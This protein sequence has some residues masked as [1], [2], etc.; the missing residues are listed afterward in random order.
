MRLAGGAIALVIMLFPAAL[1]AQPP[2]GNEQPPVGNEAVKMQ[3]GSLSIYPSLAIR[4]IGVDENVFNESVDPKSDFTIT[5]SPRA[6]ISFQPGRLKLTLSET[7]D[8][9]YFQTFGSEGGVNQSVTARADVDLGVIQPYAT[10]GGAN[11]KDRYNHEVDARARHRDRT[12]SAGVGL[13]LFT[14]TTATAGVRRIRY[15]FDE[16]A[17]FRGENLADAFNSTIDIVEGGV[18]I[19]VTPLTKFAVNVSQEDQEFDNTVDRDSR[20]LRVMPT[21][22]ISPLGLVSGTVA[23]GFRKFTA[24]DPVLQDFSGLIASVTAGTT[25]YERHR[26]DFSFNRDLNY[27][28]EPATPY[29]VYTGATLGW[30]YLIGGSFDVKASAARNTMR[31]RVRGDDSARP[32]DTFFTYSAGAG[33]RLARRLRFG[34]NADWARRDSEIAPDRTF[35]NNRIYGTVTWG[36]QR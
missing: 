28:Y 26:L 13:K 35:D 27:S 5:V 36:S 16:G 15:R 6:D 11:T 33:Y 10:I 30:T 12:Y 7:T 24:E 34:V 21:L 8:Y 19:E 3:F 17:A 1:H 2:T 22:S 29:Y 9:V 18:S 25:L 32:S 20:S 14:R 31:Y 23:V 4:N